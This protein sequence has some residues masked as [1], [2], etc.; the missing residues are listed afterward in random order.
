MI[1]CWLFLIK[2]KAK[3]QNADLIQEKIIYKP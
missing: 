2:I 1:N 3:N